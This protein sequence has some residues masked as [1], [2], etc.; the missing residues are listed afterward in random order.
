MR[1]RDRAALGEMHNRARWGAPAET[2][3]PVE[4]FTAMG[5]HVHDQPVLNVFDATTSLRARKDLSTMDPLK[6]RCGDLVMIESVVVRTQRGQGWTVSYHTD[7]V[8]CLAR[9]PQP[10]KKCPIILS[11]LHVPPVRFPLWL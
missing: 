11:P 7:G 4:R 8:F 2:A 3:Y 6:L 9:H 5:I 1:A 10:Q